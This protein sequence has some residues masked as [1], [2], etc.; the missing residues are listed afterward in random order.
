MRWANC[1]YAQL[2]SEIEDR[3]KP[4]PT[5]EKI[6]HGPPK[7]VSADR[8]AADHRVDQT[9]RGNP[10]ITGRYTPHPEP[11]HEPK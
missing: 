1:D 10:T 11:R 8:P 2:L 9:L 4:V 5:T 7:R 3:F 6:N